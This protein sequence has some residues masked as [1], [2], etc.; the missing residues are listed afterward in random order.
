MKRI[1]FKFI[2]RG[3][4]IVITISNYLT[5]IRNG[6]REVKCEN[7]VF[8]RMRCEEAIDGK[9]PGGFGAS[10]IYPYF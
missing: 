4:S 9:M 8:P 5:K 3:G 6:E 10:D 2:L 1:K 7:E